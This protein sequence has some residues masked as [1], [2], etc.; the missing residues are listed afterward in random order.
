LEIIRTSLFEKS[1]KKLGA[2]EADIEKLERELALNPEAGDVIQGLGG[3]R[4]VRFS[5]GGK[6]RSG[7]GRAIYVVV[8]RNDTAYLLLA[9][10]KAV[11]E[12]YAACGY[13]RNRQG[14]E[15]WLGQNSAPPRLI[16]S[17]GAISKQP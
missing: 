6:G 16:H 13:C 11:Q 14:H 1:L 2:T 15:R 12:E 10:S 4:K 7:G 3:A 8:W 5:M 17:S 9:Y